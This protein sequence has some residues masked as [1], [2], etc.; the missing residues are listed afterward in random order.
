MPVDTTQIM[1]EA[2]KLGQLVAQHPAVARYKQA[3]EAVDKDPEATRML[4]DLDR[5]IEN[6]TRQQQ[7]GLPVTDAQQQQL[8]ALQ[9]RIVSQLKIKNL[10]LAQVD[11][12]DLLRKV[13]QTIQRQLV[14]NPSA[15]AAG[16]QRP[17]AI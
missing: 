5:Q 2:T 8:E 1:D 12:V 16:A 17:V 3:R 10:N 7:A 6:L 14:D 11:F 13:T 15:P 4:A 9:N